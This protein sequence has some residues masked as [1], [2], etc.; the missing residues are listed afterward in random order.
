VEGKTPATPGV[1]YSSSMKS[2]GAPYRSDY[3]PH[4]LLE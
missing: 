2:A 3:L 1:K 4:V